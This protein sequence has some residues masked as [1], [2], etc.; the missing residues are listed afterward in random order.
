MAEQLIYLIG[1]LIVVDMIIIVAWV[2]SYFAGVR[3]GYRWRKLLWLVLAARL[4]IPVRPVMNGIYEDKPS[5]FVKI[6][7]PLVYSAGERLRE[8]DNKSVKNIET[9]EVS[10]KTGTT[11]VDEIDFEKTESILFQANIL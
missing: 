8:T 5:Y 3:M 1:T 6:D 9:P 11:D 7:V 4:L 10:G 2:V